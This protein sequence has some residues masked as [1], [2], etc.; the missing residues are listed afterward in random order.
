MN[1]SRSILSQIILL[2]I[3]ISICV[4][5]FYWMVTTSLKTQIVALESPPV[6][7][8]EPTLNTIAKPCSRTACCAR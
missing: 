8:F 5:P 1:T 6:W 7:M 3:I 2:L 4:F